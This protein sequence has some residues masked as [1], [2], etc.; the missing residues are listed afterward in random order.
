V[1]ISVLIPV[2][3]ELATIVQVI[4]RAAQVRW[5]EGLEAEILV[6]DD[7]STDGTT[8]RLAE[9]A[10]SGR[11][12]QMRVVHKS[13]NEGKG[14]AIATGITEA[15]GQIIAVQ[16]ADLEYDPNHLATLVEPILAGQADVVYGSRF[17]AGDPNSPFLHRLANKLLTRASNLFTGLSLTDME[18]CHKVI[19]RRCLEGLQLR[20]R[21]FGIEP[22]LTAKLARRGCRFAERPIRYAY[23]SYAAGKK[24]GFRDGVKALISI[25]YFTWFD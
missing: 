12:P 8:D 3:N 7:G 20:S 17:L 24:I 21:R 5:P 4:H 15:R 2:Y 6:I 25:V 10:S 11:Y 16:D 18:T 14:A 13:T 22:E 1:L 23:R 9:L 19:R